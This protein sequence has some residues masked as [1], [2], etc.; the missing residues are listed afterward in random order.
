MGVIRKTIIIPIPKDSKAGVKIESKFEIPDRFIELISLFFKNLT[1]K[2]IPAN[3]KMKIE[4]SKSVLV[5]L[6][7]VN[8]IIFNMKF[9]ISLSLKKTN[10][11]TKFISN[12]IDKKTAKDINKHLKNSL[13]RYLIKVIGKNFFIYLLVLNLKNF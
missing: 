10:S 3:K 5:V 7:I 9:S 2:N 12:E 4:L 1:K 11:S 13:D 6:T 8:I